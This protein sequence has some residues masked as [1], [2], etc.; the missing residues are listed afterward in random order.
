MLKRFKKQIS[1]NILLNWHSESIGALIF[2][3]Y[4]KLYL[5]ITR[6]VSKLLSTS[7]VGDDLQNF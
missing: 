6:Y 2:I 7:Y 3:L 4:L 5:K 1:Y